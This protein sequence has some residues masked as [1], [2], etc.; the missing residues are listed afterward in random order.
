MIQVTEPGIHLEQ[1]HF[2]NSLKRNAKGEVT[3]EK[4]ACEY[5]IKKLFQQTEALF[6]YLQAL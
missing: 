1:E 5:F 2:N 4:H 6:A 3:F